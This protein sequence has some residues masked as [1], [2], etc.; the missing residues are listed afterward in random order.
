MNIAMGSFQ[1]QNNFGSFVSNIQKQK[2]LV[3]HI[4]ILIPE[5]TIYI[6]ILQLKQVEQETHKKRLKAFDYTISVNKTF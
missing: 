1:N 4:Y 3:Y 2:V 6:H 5:R